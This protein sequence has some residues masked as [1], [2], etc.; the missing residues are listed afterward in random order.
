VAEP[1]DTARAVGAVP[2]GISR[3]GTWVIVS[4]DEFF[5]LLKADPRD[6]MPRPREDH[7]S[8][9]TRDREV[10]GWSTPGWKNPG[11]PQMY[12]VRAEG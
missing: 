11:A 4:Q 10:W 7:S 12:A 6:I 9:E 5:A 2:D 8:W 3:W 1:G